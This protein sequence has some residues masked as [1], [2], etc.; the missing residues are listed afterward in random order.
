MD[1]HRDLKV[2]T[3]RQTRNQQLFVFIYLNFCFRV[4]S[5]VCDIEQ[6][7]CLLKS[8]KLQNLLCNSLFDQGILEKLKRHNGMTNTEVATLANLFETVSNLCEIYA[9]LVGFV[10]ASHVDWMSEA[11]LNASKIHKEFI[12]SIGSELNLSFAN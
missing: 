2:N 10:T 1:D 3:R 6:V 9:S 4:L 8:H 5:S 7:L 12:V 11:I